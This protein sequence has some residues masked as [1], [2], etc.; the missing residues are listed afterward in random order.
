M[1]FFNL[2]SSPTLGLMKRVKRKIK[3]QETE[4]RGQ[5]AGGR[6]QEVE[7]TPNPSLE[8]DWRQEERRQEVESSPN[9]NIFSPS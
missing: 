9:E 4:G 1:S 5:E 3:R 2:H 8:G 6:K 7:P